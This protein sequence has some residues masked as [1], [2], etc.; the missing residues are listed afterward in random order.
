MMAPP[1]RSLGNSRGS[2]KGDL[3]TLGTNQFRITYAGGDGN[4]VVLSSTALVSVAV[5]PGSVGE[6]G[7]VLTY[8][9]T[10]DN[11]AGDLTVDF[12]L[13]GTA[14]FAGDYSV[15][16]GTTTAAGGSITFAPGEAQAIL[17]VTGLDDAIVEAPETVVLTL[18]DG[19]IYEI[20]APTVGDRNDHRRRPSCHHA[21]AGQF[22]GHRRGCGDHDV[23]V[24]C[25]LGGQCDRWR[26]PD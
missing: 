21:G 22:G 25:C 10:R 15:T 12:T 17:T 6:D 16:G 20:V 24:V 1:I 13:G 11:V 5:T 2:L 18:V 9:L 26:I 8:T 14:T 23:G 19:P 7:G 4:D 3:L